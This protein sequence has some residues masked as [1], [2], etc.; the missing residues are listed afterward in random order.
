MK[1]L[2]ILLIRP[3]LGLGVSPGVNAPAR[4]EP[5]ALAILAALT[6]EDIEVEAY[7][8]R[9]EEIPY[10]RQAD[11]VALSVCTFSAKRAYEIAE[12]WQGKGVP[13]IMGGFHPT[14]CPSEVS[15]HADSIAIGDAEQTWPRVIADLRNNSLEKIYRQDPAIPA[16]IMTPDRSIFKGKR[17]LPLSL[18]Q[19]SRGCPRSCD[20]CSIHNFY[21]GT[22]SFRNIDEVV[23]ELKS[24]PRFRRK[25]FFVDDNLLS[26]QGKIRPFLEA[27]I[28][29]KLSWSSQADMSFA[30][31]DELLSLVTRSGCQSV[32]IGFESLN[33]ACI[34]QMG[35][36]C[37]NVSLYRNRL[38]KIRRA[39]IM[40]YGSFLFGY[41]ADQPDIFEQ[42][43]RFAC[44]EKLFMA[45]FNPLQALPGT[46]LYDRLL[47][48]EGLV[49]D[50]WWLDSRYRW[51]EALIKPMNMTAHELTQG[52]AEAR[53]RFHR[54]RSILSRL[55]EKN[56][57]A[58]DINNA[59]CFL[60]TN[61][62]SRWD[63]KKNTG[64]KLG[65]NETHPG[66]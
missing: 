4:M 41:D 59:V 2:R 27:L 6:P 51:N 32:I 11:L 44:E 15:E 45:N 38:D 62:V 64:L 57:N 31:D 48:E 39:G 50:T 22:V 26:N 55:F 54:Y 7:D 17:Y 18:V 49:Y 61:L 28:P 52:C 30:D 12:K 33:N 13:V 8:D 37:N 58:K 46:K 53:E 14:L 65:M 34:K 21:N 36:S 25:I 16:A 35:K 47:R 24:L 42:T 60:A 23:G 40:V 56:A 29:L 3:R 66:K 1:T 63:I 5:L 19:F 43:L 9:F 20:F 10:D